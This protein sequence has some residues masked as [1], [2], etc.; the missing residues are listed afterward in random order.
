MTST[1]PDDPLFDLCV[2]GAGIAGLNALFVAQSYLPK[3]ARVALVDR[4]PA[5][6]GMWTEA[7]DFVRLHQPHPMFTA[8][9]IAWDWDKP[10]GHLANRSEVVA[11]FAHCLAVLA[12]HFDLTPCF[13]H[14]MTQIQERSQGPVSI[15]IAALEGG[16]SQVLRAKRVIH[17]PGYDVAAPAPLPLSAGVVRTLS[18]KDLDAAALADTAPAYVVGGG[19]TGMDTALALMDANPAREV[20]VLTGS[21]TLFGN[22]DRFMP[23]GLGRWLSGKLLV[24]VRRDVCLRFDGTNEGQVFDYFARTYGHAPTSAPARHL[25]GLMSEAECEAVRTR[26]H[27]LIEDYL[28]DVIDTDQG[29]QMVL[30]TGAHRPV[31]PGSVFLNC[32]GHLL[33]QVP[34]APPILSPAGKVLTLS[35]SATVS[36]LSSASAYFLTHLYFL[37]TLGQSRVSVLNLPLLTQSAGP[38]LTQMAIMTQ[39]LL[40]ALHLVNELPFEAIKRCGL[41]LDRWFPFPRRALGFVRLKRQAPALIAHCEGSLAAVAARYAGTCAPLNTLVV[42]DKTAV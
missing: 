11:H 41:D 42:S 27:A 28:D 36:F 33:R 10:R 34:E 2:I 24:N 38:Q 17:A 37:G 15:L 32:T 4:K 1:D 26:T 16:G 30:R 20:S 8:G 5:P 29:P 35:Q 6:G 19:K 40:N 9:D 21:G 3:G 7:Y 13:G 39:T 22:R 14:E 31:A 25:F 12:Q 18:P 23:T